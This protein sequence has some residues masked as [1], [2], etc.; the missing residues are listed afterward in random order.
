MICDILIYR[1][2]ISGSSDT[3]PLPDVLSSIQD[4]IENDG[5]FLYTHHGNIRLRVDPNCSLEITSFSDPEYTGE[6][7]L[8]SRVQASEEL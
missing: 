2:R 5:T 4:W 6:L 7:F 8:K 3:L 1:A